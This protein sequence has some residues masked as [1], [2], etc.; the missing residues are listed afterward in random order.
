MTAARDARSS[1]RRPA[2][3]V[4]DAPALLV[5]APSSGFGGGIERVAVAVEAAWPGPVLRVNLYRHEQVAVAAGRPVTKM[6]FAVRACAAATRIRPRL[7]LAIHAGLLPVAHVAGAL[8]R[9]DVALTA[10]GDEVWAPMT[11]RQQRL[12]QRCR[13]L[14]AVS[15]FTAEWLARR[16]EIE[17]SRVSVVPLSVAPEFASRLS[18]RPPDPVAATT[19]L[20]VSRIDSQHRYKGHFD[21]AA[22]LPLVLSSEPDARW[23]VIGGGD[24]LEGLRAACAEAGVLHATDLRGKVSDGELSE[25]YENAFPGSAEHRRPHGDA[26]RR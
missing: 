17:R 26:A 24:G 12:I 6:S 14:M 5:L 15:S 21:I 4:I 18:S 10:H 1:S 19:F 2:L 16:A 23:V 20:T 22:A 9:A 25:A 13:N 8:V 11:R 7:I 3:K